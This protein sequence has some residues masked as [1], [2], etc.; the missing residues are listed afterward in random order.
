M[1][2]SR[3]DLQ[4]RRA[5]D[6]RVELSDSGLGRVIPIEALWEIDEEFIGFVEDAIEQADQI[7]DGDALMRL[8]EEHD[9]NLFRKWSD[10]ERRQIQA[11][12]KI[13]DLSQWPGA[14]VDDLMSISALETF[15]KDQA[16]LDDRIRGLLH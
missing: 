8:A 10:E 16:A 2:I 14:P 4:P 15:A 6:L 5:E 3:Q 9:V 7:R 1:E 11:H 13:P 12:G